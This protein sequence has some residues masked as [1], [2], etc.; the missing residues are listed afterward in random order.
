[1]CIG[2]D[3]RYQAALVKPWREFGAFFDLLDAVAGVKLD[4]CATHWCSCIV[5]FRNVRA[6]DYRSAQ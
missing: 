6:A 1:L 4:F 3:S 5:L 2:R